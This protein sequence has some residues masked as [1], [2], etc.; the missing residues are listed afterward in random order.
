MRGETGRRIRREGGE[1]GVAARRTKVQKGRE[2][3]ATNMAGLYREELLGE[4]QP[5]PLVQGRWQRMQAIPCDRLELKDAGRTWQPC[6]A[7]VC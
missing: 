3:R 1:P 4:G 6:P 7:L 2:G 5:S